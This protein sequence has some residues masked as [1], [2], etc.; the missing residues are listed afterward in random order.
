MFY[1]FRS[2]RIEIRYVSDVC[3]VR[4][5]NAAYSCDNTSKSKHYTIATKLCEKKTC[6]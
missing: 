3:I 2:A 5:I 1:D 6:M 4:E